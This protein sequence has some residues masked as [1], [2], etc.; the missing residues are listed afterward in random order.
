VSDDTGV[1]EQISS[2]GWSVGNNECDAYGNCSSC[3]VGSAFGYVGAYTG[4]TRLLHLINRYYDPPTGQFLSVDPGT[5]PGS[6]AKLSLA[7][8]DESAVLVDEM[9]GGRVRVS[10]QCVTGRVAV[11]A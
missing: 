4:S 3:D 1:R 6:R 10:V 11:T 5:S 9:L 7:M 2:A 8:S